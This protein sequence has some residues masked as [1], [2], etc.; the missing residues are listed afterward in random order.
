METAAATKTTWAIDPSHSEVHFK[1][2][3]LMISTVTGTI[4]SFEGTAETIDNDFGNAQISFSADS[5]SISTGDANRDGHLNSADFFESEAHPK[6]TFTSTKMEKNGEGTYTMHGDLNIK[7]ISKNIALN[8]EF[9]GIATDPWG[10][11]KAGFTIT[12]LVNRKDWGL[13]WNA[14]LEAGG[15]LLADDVKILCE[16][17]L[18]QV[19]A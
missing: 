3:H 14:A 12:G 17:Q 9:A 8:V 4:G 1:I 16:V 11:K 7:G 18:A 15:F 10:N 13:N 6:I 19:N 5:N 2:K